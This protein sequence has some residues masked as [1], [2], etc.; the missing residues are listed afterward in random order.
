MN[1]SR[2]SFPAGSVEESISTMGDL[3]FIANEAAERVH[4]DSL[5]SPFHKCARAL[6]DGD[7]ETATEQW[8]Q[9]RCQVDRLWESLQTFE[10]V[11]GHLKE[12]VERVR[13]LATFELVKVGSESEPRT[14]ASPEPTEGPEMQES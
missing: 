5:G 10:T 1:S 7:Y 3:L 11:A 6:A 14:T 2:Y 12:R 8:I 13:V 9:G 4:D